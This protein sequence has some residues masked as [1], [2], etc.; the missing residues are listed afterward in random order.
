MLKQLGPIGIIGALLVLVG[1]AVIA[2]ENTT[3]AIGLA[4][5]FIG[6][7]MVAKAGV[8]AVMGLFG[9]A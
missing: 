4:L 9:M 1:I 2:I 5:A 7:G 3:I 8:D 6:L